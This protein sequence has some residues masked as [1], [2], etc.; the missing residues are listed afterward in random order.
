M[1]QGALHGW[2]LILRAFSGP[3]GRVLIEQPSYPAAIDAVRAHHARPQPVAVTADGWHWPSG[4]CGSADIAYFVP[5]FQNPTG[6]RLLTARGGSWSGG[7]SACCSWWTRRAL[8]WLF[9]G[10]YAYGGA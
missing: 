7:R 9:A 8:S 4:L 10:L 3:G 1:T 2:D 5:D 6:H